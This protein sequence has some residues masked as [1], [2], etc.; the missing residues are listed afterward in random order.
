LTLFEDGVY[1]R[2]ENL[3]SLA[4]FTGKWKLEDNL[5]TLVDENDEFVIY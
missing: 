1:E 3:Y 4:T 5:L 2:T